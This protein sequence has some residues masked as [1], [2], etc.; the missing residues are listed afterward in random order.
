MAD[1]YRLTVLKRLTDHLKGIAPANG[2]AFDLSNNVFR[3]RT[4][5]GEGD[6]VPLISILESPR[7]DSGVYAGSESSERKEGWTLLIQGWAHDDVENPTDPLYDLMDAV[8]RRLQRII[9]ESNTNGA[10]LFPDEFLLGRSIGGLTVLPGVVSP[11][12]EQVS[13]KA[14]FYLPVRV[15]LVRDV[16]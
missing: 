9:A 2:Y 4:I 10:A 12:R 16:G 14:F 8:E 3:G 5:F 15:T 7:S 11:A 13:S 1:S 6:P